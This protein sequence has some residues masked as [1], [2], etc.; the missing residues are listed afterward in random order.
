MKLQYWIDYQG[1]KS[2]IKDLIVDGGLSCS[3]S[4]GAKTFSLVKSGNVNKKKD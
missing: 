4:N 2:P 3:L 1:K